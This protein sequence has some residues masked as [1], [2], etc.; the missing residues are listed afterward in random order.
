MIREAITLMSVQPDFAKIDLQTKYP[1]GPVAVHGN[2]CL[3]QQLVTNL[4]LNSLHATSEQTGRIAVILEKT[5]SQAILYVSD[6]GCGIPLAHL[7]KVFDPFFTAMPP[8]RGT[9]LGLSICHSIVQQH[10]GKIEIASREGQGT[11]VKV[12]LPLAK[13]TK[14]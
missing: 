6:T 7:K 14:R 12:V 9:G 4:V 10:E 1:D 5:S 11:T 3:L 13:E 2:A 8:G